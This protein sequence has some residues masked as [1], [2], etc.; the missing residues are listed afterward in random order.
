[1][2]N[3]T[4][5]YESFLSEE[6]RQALQYC[7]KVADRLNIPIFLIGGVV[8]DIILQKN[9]VDIDVTVQAN[10]INFAKELQKEY[11]GFCQI[12]DIYE[13][14]KTAKICFEINNKKICL[15]V[16]STR[17]EIYKTPT[18]LPVIVKIGCD[19]YEDIIRRDF[20]IN[21]MA[22]ILNE[23]EFCTLV[24]PLNGF[25]DLKNRKLKVLHD[26]SFID[27]P[28]RIIRGLKFSVRFDC[29]LD[30]HTKM[31][32]KECLSD[33]RFQNMGTERLKSELQ[34]TFDLNKT[35][36]LK[37][38]INENIYKLID[39]DIVANRT[40]ESI[41]N[42][43]DEYRQFFKTSQHIW[44]IY[45]SILLIDLPI[46]KIAQISSKL[47]LRGVETEILLNSKGLSEKIDQLKNEIS[48][49]NIYK[50]L[51]NYCPEAIIANL[52]INNSVVIKEKIDL[53]FNELQHIKI[54]SSGTD[55]IN[56]GLLPGPV[57]GEVLEK[58]LELKINQKINTYEEE[59]NFIRNFAARY[60]AN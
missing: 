38:L 43:V 37:K 20:T 41:E 23:K 50:I 45:L 60:F 16:A 19:I 34:Q 13:D 53:F 35:I 36:C 25:E 18:S 14:F 10:A 4:N 47:N 56:V 12:Q 22:L 29:G 15:D 49:F 59:L 57:F 26:K 58:L 44:L 39:V 55:L 1:M 8:R 24:D 17:K 5:K 52:T 33:V 9:C 40:F 54:Q 46:N 42:F 48:R 27:D 2:I 30:E 32:Q 6:Y 51:I 7:A 31:L 28:T 11:S 21:S 3:L